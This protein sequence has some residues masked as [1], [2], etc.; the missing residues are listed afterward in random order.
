MGSIPRTTVVDRLP[1]SLYYLKLDAVN[2]SAL[3]AVLRTTTPQR[4]MWHT[5]RETFVGR[6]KPK[7]DETEDKQDVPAPAAQA[8]VAEATVHAAEA[9]A[10]VI[11]D[12][13]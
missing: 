11:V 4:P 9:E 13:T 8:D 1:P 2:A 12:Q 10:T 6:A 3:T 7:A 5:G